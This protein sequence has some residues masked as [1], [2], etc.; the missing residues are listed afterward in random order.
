MS[1]EGKICSCIIA[2][3]IFFSS[4]HAQQA[5][6]HF[7]L[8]GARI[9][10]GSGAPWFT[11]DVAISG[12]CIAAIGDLRNATVCWGFMSASSSISGNSKEDDA[13]NRDF[14]AAALG[15]RHSMSWDCTVLKSAGYGLCTDDG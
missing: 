9:V 3:A 6:Y 15:L 2:I 8:S 11:G 7:I 4:L 1:K 13:A 14:S 12:D 10:D 5:S